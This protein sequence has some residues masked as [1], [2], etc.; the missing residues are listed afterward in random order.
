[1][2]QKRMRLPVGAT[3]QDAFGGQFL[4]EKLLGKGGDGSVYL[5]RDRRNTQRVFALKEM[6]NPSRQDRKRL[7]FERKVLRRLYHPALPRVYHVIEQEKLKRVYLLMEYI[8]GQ[9]LDVLRRKQP[10]GRFS[11]EQALTILGP[12]ADALI[13]LHKQKPPIL[14]RDIK[15]SN[16]IVP[17]DG[18][19]ATL[20]DFGTAKE[21]I[22][23]NTTTMFRYGTPGYAPIEQY[24]TRGI[25]GVRTDIFGLGATLYS[26][27]TGVQ[28]IDAIERITKGPDVLQPPHLLV[29]DIPQSVSLAIQ[30]ALSIHYEDRFATVEDFWQALH[31]HDNE[32]EEELT[33]LRLQDTHRPTPSTEEKQ[34]ETHHRKPNRKRIA[35]FSLAS[36][37]L[38]ILCLLFLF[39]HSA[40]LE[41][42]TQHTSSPKS[43]VTA[44]LLRASPGARI[45]LYPPITS[46]Y[47]GTISD[48]AVAHKTTKLYLSQIRQNQA[49]IAGNFQG[50]GLIGS[51]TGKVSSVGNIRLIIK[52]GLGTL[53]FEGV[54]KVGGDMEGSFYTMDQYEH[55]ISEYGLWYASET[56]S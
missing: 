27:L 54:I 16:I 14:H 18:G 36:I 47:A 52:Y 29:S 39:T 32:P 15:P 51:F 38:F 23:E 40:L 55:N 7:L 24:S 33:P 56:S 49:N 10:E 42:F 9:D 43:A 6:I 5:V 1:M 8:R 17:P 34:Q 44:T 26:L 35:V 50:L 25:T 41:P 11:V 19:N 37:T 21:H 20:V 30:K 4:V 3:I 22:P 2:V 31:S 28:P 13:Y 53:I 12:I 46:T 45:I 48:I